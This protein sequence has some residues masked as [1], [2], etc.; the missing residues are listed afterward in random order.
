VQN[1]KTPHEAI[2]TAVQDA[3]TE[4]NGIGNA[5]T[6]TALMRRLLAPDMAWALAALKPDGPPR[7]AAIRKRRDVTP[8]PRVTRWYECSSCLWSAVAEY[9]RYCENCGARIEWMTPPVVT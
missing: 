2:R 7:I 1:A 5:D 9:C 6:V 4:V 8:G 3:L